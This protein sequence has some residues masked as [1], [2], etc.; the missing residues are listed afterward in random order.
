[1]QTIDVPITD[2]I[3]FRDLKEGNSIQVRVTVS[4]DE[5]KRIE[6]GSSVKITFADKT[7]IAKIVSEPI[8]IDEKID[9]SHIVLSLIVE[10]A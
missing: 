7:A 2:E 3:S 8:V 6:K 10:E 9:D 1:M 5:Q 4:N